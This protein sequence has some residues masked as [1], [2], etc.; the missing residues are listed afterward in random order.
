MM[1]DYPLQTMVEDNI[2]G[3]LWEVLQIYLEYWSSNRSPRTEYIPD[4]TKLVF[5]ESKIWL[6]DGNICS[7]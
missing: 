3:F 2:F 1:S 5:K 4:F 7:N 6:P